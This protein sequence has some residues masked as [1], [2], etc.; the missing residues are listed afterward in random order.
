MVWLI[1]QSHMHWV[2]HEHLGHGLIC[3]MYEAF[4]LLLMAIVQAQ[5]AAL[6]SVLA[7]EQLLTIDIYTD[8]ANAGYDGK[9][10]VRIGLPTFEITMGDLTLNAGLWTN[11]T[12]PTPRM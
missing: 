12:R 11:T 9:T 8:S 6:L 3:S 10:Y 7:T 4:L 2:L 5:K 1:R